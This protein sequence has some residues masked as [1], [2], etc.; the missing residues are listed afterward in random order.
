MSRHHARALT[1]ALP[2]L[3]SA[4]PLPSKA[5]P[6]KPGVTARRPRDHG[7]PAGP[8]RL[9]HTVRQ[10]DS[11]WTI[12]RRG[13]PPEALAR[14][15]RLEGG[16]PLRPGQHLR[17]PTVAAPGNQ[18]PA[19]WPRSSG[20]P[21]V[22]P[23]VDFAWPVAASVGSPFGPRLRGWHGGIDLQA[24]RGTPI[25]AA[26]PGMVI[27]SGW[28]GGYGRVVKIWHHADLMTVYAHN[29]ENYVRVGDW[30]EGARSSARWEARTRQR[31]PPPL[32][33]PARR[34]EVRPALL[35][36]AGE[37]GRVAAVGPGADRVP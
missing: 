12:A 33:D 24:E 37:P 9:G 6:A 8:A 32:R 28:E 14:A 23:G 13:V 26:A 30:V 15:N 2:L 27:M 19:S 20:P 16:R 11:L 21:P 35:A 10:G 4:L 22:T 1:L 29:Q 7:A 36:S 17:I 34:E 31:R 25:R 3:L 5:E 18:E